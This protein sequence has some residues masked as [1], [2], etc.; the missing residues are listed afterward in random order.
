MISGNF[1]YNK[2]RENKILY[3]AVAIRFKTAYSVLWILIKSIYYDLVKPEFAEKKIRILYLLLYFNSQEI[4]LNIQVIKNHKPTIKKTTHY[5][6]TFIKTSTCPL[7][8]P[9]QN[10]NALVYEL[11][12]GLLFRG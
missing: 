8:Q 7:I 10:T 11:Y 5:L 12:Q 9:G 3:I 2:N 6:S 4:K 1:R